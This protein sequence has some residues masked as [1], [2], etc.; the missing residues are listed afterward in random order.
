MDSNKA[1]LVLSRLYIGPLRVARNESL[2]RHLN[3]THVLT[4][5]PTRP[6]RFEGIVYKI[7]SV[8]DS[9]N[10]RID[11]H[12]DE[13]FEFINNALAQ[14]GTVYVHCFQGVSR[15][16]SVVIAYLMKY[17]KMKFQRAFDYL[18]KR[19]NIIN[20]NF[21]FVDQLKNFESSLALSQE[22]ATN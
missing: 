18:K 12:F 7:V 20:P 21:G 19:R 17:R 15:S 1:D 14:G 8:S 4:V 10:H 9:P 16:A 2:L 6:N 11:V 22:L 13:C 3:V 5:C